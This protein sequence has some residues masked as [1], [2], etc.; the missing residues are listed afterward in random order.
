MYRVNQKYV[1]TMLCVNR[2]NPNAHC[3]GHC[4]LKK[5][6]NNE[7][8]PSKPLSAASK[9]KLE[10]QLFFTEGSLFAFMQFNNAVGFNTLSFAFTAQGLIRKCFKPPCT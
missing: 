10:V 2:N 5:Q 4:Y 1:A 6:L 7:E 3:N 8:H 9:E